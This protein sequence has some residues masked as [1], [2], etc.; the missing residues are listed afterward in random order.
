M[1][2]TGFLRSLPDLNP[3]LVTTTT[4][5]P[6]SVRPR[7]AIQD[8]MDP[9]TLNVKQLMK[10]CVEE[11]TPDG[12]MIP[13]CVYNSVG[14]REQVR[15]AMSGVTVADVVPNATG[16]HPALA[17][18][19]YGSKIARSEDTHGNDNGHR[20]QPLAPDTTNVGKKIR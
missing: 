10:C 15:E 8:F 5:T 12:Q 18:S 7:V 4:G 16:L 13:F 20:N 6:R 9:Y 14:Y 17:D 3:T 2:I 1:R 11:I 19:P